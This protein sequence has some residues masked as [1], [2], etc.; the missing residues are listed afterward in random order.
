MLARI[1]RLFTVKTKFEA[2]LLIYALGLGAVERGHTYLQ[3]Y[4][5]PFGWVLFAACTGAVF[6]AGSKI[7]DGLAYSKLHR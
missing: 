7:L 2:F 6:L 1:A 3:Q 4:P 5:G